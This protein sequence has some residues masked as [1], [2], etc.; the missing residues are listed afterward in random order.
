MC[1]KSPVSVCLFQA[2]AR[3]FSCDLFFDQ[4][5]HWSRFPRADG[6]ME[7]ELNYKFSLW[8]QRQM[9]QTMDRPSPKKNVAQF[10]D[11]VF[12]PF[13][14]KTS[15]F[16]TVTCRTVRQVTFCAT[17]RSCTDKGRDKSLVSGQTDIQTEKLVLLS[18]SDVLSK[19][20]P[21][22]SHF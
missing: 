6:P 10:W 7:R 20:V 9:R 2:H 13:Q 17:S 16:N 12:S 3:D 21:W 19:N 11:R 4:S 14:I 22:S 5:M 1:E 18:N 8:S 15:H